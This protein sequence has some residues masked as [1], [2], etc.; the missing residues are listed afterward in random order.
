MVDPRFI[1]LLKTTVARM[2][3]EIM[4]PVSHI[5]LEFWAKWLKKFRENNRYEIIKVLIKYFSLYHSSQ[6]HLLD[7]ITIYILFF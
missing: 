3:G 4:I 7:I 1:A 6:L 2:A 5:N